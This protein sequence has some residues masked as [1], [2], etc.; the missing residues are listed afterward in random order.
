MLAPRFR[1]GDW[2]SFLYGPRKVLAKVVE[3]R[4]PLG[5]HRRRLYRV[6][7]DV[8]RDESTTFEIPEEELQAATDADKAAWVETGSTGLHQ[9]MS[10]FGNDEDEH[11]IPK[12]WYHYLVVASPGPRAGSGVAS[13][14][15]LSEAKASGVAQDPSTTIAAREGGPEAALSKAEEYLDSRHPGLKKVVNERKS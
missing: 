15:E 4:G 1:I 10:Y 2:V 5:V 11:G 8:D 7:L 12:P 6:R 13:I 9:T 14:I 3:D